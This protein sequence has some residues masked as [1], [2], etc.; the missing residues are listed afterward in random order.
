MRPG[1]QPNM[2]QLMKQAQKMQQQMA[3][4]RRSW[5]RPRSSVPP[6]AVW[7]PS[8]STGG[9]NVK[10]I[11]IDPA[12][13]DPDDVETLE[14]LL[15]AAF[16]NAADAARELTEQKMGPAHGRARRP[17]PAGS[18]DPTMFEGALQ[19]L[20]D[21]LGRLPGIGPKSAQRIAFHVLSADPVDVKRLAAALRGSRTKC[22]SARPASTS[23][24][25]SSAGFAATRAGP[26][27]RSASSRSRRTSSRSRRP[28][29]SAAATT[30][31]A[32]RSIR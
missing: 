26:K 21:E 17:R 28:A 19:D 24:S 27:R 18:V 7:C 1:G 12:V 16:N 10:S 6:A 31:S 32:G 20:I 2:Q 15:M 14:D 25:R 23:P 9:G 5:P 11:K 29:N 3:A 8:P 13:V 22:G 4:R 30:C